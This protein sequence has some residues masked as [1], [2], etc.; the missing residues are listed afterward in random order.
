[1]VIFSSDLTI[2][3]LLNRYRVRGITPHKL[4]KRGQNSKLHNTQVNLKNY[5]VNLACKSAKLADDINDKK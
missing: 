3:K 4:A 5:L 1:M 2:I